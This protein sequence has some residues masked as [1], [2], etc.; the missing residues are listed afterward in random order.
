MPF[1][2]E[3]TPFLVIKDPE[4]V[5]PTDLDQQLNLKHVL[6]LNQHWRQLFQV[7]PFNVK[8]HGLGCF[9]VAD[10]NSDLINPGFTGDNVE[11]V[12][13]VLSWLSLASLEETQPKAPGQDRLINH[14]KHAAN[15]PL[16]ATIVYFVNEHWQTALA[17]YITLPLSDMQLQARS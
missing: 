3:L 14:I 17:Y 13:E 11:P 2:Q 7:Q 6:W 12:S 5:V 15:Y 9:V 1:F 10:D 8:Q 16:S 4:L